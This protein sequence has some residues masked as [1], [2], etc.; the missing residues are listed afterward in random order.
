MEFSSAELHSSVAIN[1][2]EPFDYTYNYFN[3]ASPLITLKAQIAPQLE[4]FQKIVKF[5]S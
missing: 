5:K 4:V 3:I 1:H 2:L